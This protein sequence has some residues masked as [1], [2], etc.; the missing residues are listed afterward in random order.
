M[1]CLASCLLSH[2]TKKGNSTAYMLYTF[3]T[4]YVLQLKW[5]MIDSR[6][7][8]SIHWC[9]RR[10]KILHGCSCTELYFLWSRV[11]CLMDFGTACRFAEWTWTWKFRRAVHFSATDWWLSF[12]HSIPWCG[13]SSPE[14]PQRRSASVHTM[15]LVFMI[16]RAKVSTDHSSVDLIAR[17]IQNFISRQGLICLAKHFDWDLLY[18]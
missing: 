15:D 3:R 13:Q 12:H 4:L 5:S 1:H 6:L 9:K 18:G 14:S 11:A 7:R 10:T 2:S 17:H 16:L 8:I